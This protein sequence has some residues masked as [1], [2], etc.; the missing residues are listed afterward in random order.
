MIGEPEESTGSVRETPIVSV[1][2]IAE[3][4]V[5]YATQQNGLPVV[6]KITITNLVKDSFSDIKVCVQTQ[7][8]FASPWETWISR[9]SPGEIYSLDP[10]D[11]V[12]S[13]VFLQNVTERLTGSVTVTLYAGDRQIGSATSRISIYA[14][15]EWIGIVPVP[16]ILAAFVT[17]N[18]PAIALVLRSASSLLASW[19]GDSAL[20]GYQ[21]QSRKRAYLMTQAIF[22]ALQKEDIRYAHTPASFEKGGQKIR[23]APRVLK[24]RLGN[25]LDISVLVSSCLEQAGLH[26]LIV[27]LPD[28][29]ITGVWLTDETFPGGASDTIIPLRKRV[30]LGEICIFDAVAITSDHSGSFQEAVLSGKK[31]ISGES[32][33]CCVLDITFTR[34]VLGIR[35]LT[36][37]GLSQG[38][39]Q[40]PP[41]IREK[42]S[43]DPVELSPDFTDTIPA[44]ITQPQPHIV[45]ERIES[46]KRSLL[47]L[48][49]KN[50]LLHYTESK[51]TI[52]FCPPPLHDLS[53]SFSSGT[54]FQ[55]YSIKIL[56]QNMQNLDL[57]Q[58]PNLTGL[59]YQE[60]FSHRLYSPTPED[61]IRARLQ[62][63]YKTAQTSRKE[64]G[65]DT[66]FLAVG[67]LRWYES[68]SSDTP[69]L[70]PIILIP[71]ELSRPS[72][73]EEFSLTGKDGQ[74]SLN[75][76]LLHLLR[77][78]FL[79]TIPGLDPVPAKT[80]GIDT[81]TILKL[82]GQAI[83]NIPRWE[84]LDYACLS[85]FSFSKYHIWQD[86]ESRSDQLLHSSLIASLADPNTR[87]GTGAET[88][89][90]VE[91]LETRYHPEEIFC[92]LSTDSSQLAAVLAAGEGRTF[93]LHG[94]PGTGK[95]QTIANIIAH[96]MAKGRTVLFVSE[97]QVA[98]DVVLERLKECGLGPFCLDMHSESSSKKRV[99]AQ[100]EE[101]LNIAQ[102]PSPCDRHKTAEELSTV[103][104]RLHSYADALFSER[105]TRESLYYAIQQ[106]IR[107]RHVPLV[108]LSWPSFD[109]MNEEK[110]QELQRVV[111]QL[112]LAYKGCNPPATHPWHPITRDTYSIG[113][114]NSVHDAL[115][116]VRTAVSEIRTCLQTL[117][118]LIRGEEYG[119]GA[120]NP[121]E[122]L[123]I[124][125]LIS[126]CSTTIPAALLKHPQFETIQKQAE[127]VIRTGNI[128][129]AARK[130]LYQRYTPNILTLDLRHLSDLATGSAKKGM[131][132]RFREERKIR[133]QLKHVANP[134][135]SV[136][137][138]GIA[139]DLADAVSVVQLELFIQDNNRAGTRY[140]GE[141]WNEGEADWDQLR[142]TITLCRD[143]RKHAASLA[144]N[145]Q[146]RS[147]L[148]L[149]R[150]HSLI[151]QEK[152]R[153]Q[154]LHVQFS[155]RVTM[156]H[157][158]VSTLTRLLGCD[159]I[160]A[161]GEKNCGT[162]L[163][164]VASRVE[165]WSACLDQLQPWCVWQ[166]A[167]KEGISHG[168]LPL[169]EYVE[170]ENCAD[171][172]WKA[173]FRRGY[174]QWW[175]DSLR[176][177][178]PDLNQFYRP[179]FEDLLGHYHQI[180]ERFLLETQQEI[181]A[182]V[183]EN[184]QMIRSGQ[185][186]QEMRILQRQV[187][188]Q[189]NHLPL[190]LL[191]AKIATILPQ[192][193]PC[194]LMS[195][196]SVSRYLGP[197]VEMFDLVVFDEAS[198]VPVWDAAGAL[199]R[200]KEAVIVG[201]P[202]QL[203]PT[204][205]FEKSYP[206]IDDEIQ[207]LESVLDDCIAAR[208]PSLHLRWHYRS[209]NQSLIAFSNHH[210]YNNS[211]LTFPSPKKAPALSFRHIQGIF[212]RGK[213]RTNRR[214]A[215]A[216]VEEM[217]K[218]LLDPETAEDSMGVVTFSASQQ[219]LIISLL[220]EAIRNHPEIESCCN[221]NRPDTIFVKN[222]E[223]VQGDERD[224]ILFSVGYGP[225][226]Q[227]RISL[228]FGPLN[229]TGGE[230]RLNVAITRARKEIVVFSSL[231]ASD[232]D[233]TRT[234]ADGVRLLK[235]FLFYAE[236]GPSSLAL[237]EKNPEEMNNSAMVQEVYDTLVKRGYPVHTRVGYG[238]YTV[239]LA[240]CD[241]ANPDRYILGIECEGTGYCQAETVRDR[242]Y[243]KGIILKNLGWK[244]HRI[245]ILD[246]WDDPERELAR[247]EE[248]IGEVRGSVEM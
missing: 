150:W 131:I 210:F 37:P 47:D 190:R 163:D 206:Y 16:G 186:E 175:A 120:G 136:T 103:R 155:E 201:D 5:H 196:V 165:E 222:L 88:F 49:Q 112:S 102:V 180:E 25:C 90:R 78:E 129:D 171:P 204:R 26:P 244:M 18:D 30:S 38:T 19:T 169:I 87:C 20:S 7:P 164:S 132:Q 177:S 13:S 159:P 99:L 183:T 234:D 11:L 138:A 60:L 147:G 154:T 89:P 156:F 200:G 61:E 146:N 235:S 123:Q 80:R 113:W 187:K 34:R 148:L 241:P 114:K 214:E 229:R 134:G 77:T 76:T 184:M 101:V 240:I 224:V 173:L 31:Q 228:N 82:I 8:A 56:E 160:R 231:H 17:P 207:D 94:P 194:L 236:H 189:R 202:M 2:I 52:R 195:P 151:S 66:L 54:G 97:K 226:S 67:M 106:L 65:S 208:I 75:T 29:A 91:E 162:Y 221:E 42:E 9:I 51:E 232:I 14:Y 124:L 45:Y 50:R 237:E 105:K 238:G 188:L 126:V 36:I 157:E 28:H 152:D 143:L 41:E 230:R 176:D 192:L 212:D 158:S 217:V 185:E 245:W 95:S 81:K 100:F 39:I 225:D 71:A 209:H 181:K 128:R 108:P 33:S 233:L 133:R 6:R 247:I 246:W 93:V 72:A 242:E 168:L 84:V 10:V 12:L 44:G 121:D 243:Q 118:P 166:A 48:S 153:I 125:S 197:E 167:R 57:L 53:E 149:E 79:L 55:I 174:Y 1:A 213:T 199:S 141:A 215:E 4:A 205:I 74:G 170:D 32:L 178:D 223:N 85:H 63:L 46:W 216:V 40:K 179:V 110:L 142:Q 211:L 218:R 21:S 70:A 117:I 58:D 193:K 96:C 161:F 109:D 115:L 107:H 43:R 116:E 15:N 59:L 137:D 127:I 140:F 23:L 104:H 73:V 182:R 68:E 22:Y 122:I 227:G 139:Q 3:E 35:P 220:D 145:E 135:Y 203:P 69:L 198:Q 24:D 172:D 111:H 119:E 144:D 219:D 130:N 191:F 27:L 62:R 64:T 248:V 239:D 92:P 86:L 83:K 98:L